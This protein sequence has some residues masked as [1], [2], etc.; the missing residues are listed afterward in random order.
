[1][2]IALEA[3]GDDDA[4]TVGPK[5]VGLA[6]LLRL[7]LPVPP[8]F[9]LTTG[10]YRALLQGPESHPD[11]SNALE[12]LAQAPEEDRLGLLPEIRDAIVGAP[13]PEPVVQQVGAHLDAL[14]NGA[15]AVRSSA[16]GEDGADASFAGQYE[17]VLGVRGEDDLRSAIKQCVL[18]VDGARASAYREDQAGGVSVSMN[19]VVQRMVNARAAGV[20]FTADP[21]S[22]RRDLLVIDAV[23]GLGEAL[24]SGEATPD[25]YAINNVGV[26]EGEG[27]II[28]RELVGEA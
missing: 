11:L 21:I 5:A 4:G 23:E 6:R 10:V 3:I 2:V 24:V 26:G 14:G 1:M 16:L 18:S 28:R 13:F 19:G 12:R 22:A 7:G 27:E 8:G 25:H 15:V 20:V 9:C 17:T